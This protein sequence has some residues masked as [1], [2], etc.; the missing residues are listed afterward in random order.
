MSVVKSGLALHRVLFE[1]GAV[2][3]MA[4]PEKWLGSHGLPRRRLSRRLKCLNPSQPQPFAALDLPR[5]Q[6][7]P[8][9]YCHK[10]TGHKKQ[11]AAR[12]APRRN[13]AWQREVFSQ[14]CPNKYNK[15]EVIKAQKRWAILMGLS[16]MRFGTN[17][18]YLK[19]KSGSIIG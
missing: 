8:H 12:Q 14:D 5:G 9:P 10:P 15:Y 18:K 17:R 19:P 2:L 16:L 13:K 3:V 6:K 7:Q 1:Q 11:Q 4:R